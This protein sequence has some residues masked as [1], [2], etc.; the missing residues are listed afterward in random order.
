MYRMIPI[1]PQDR[2]LIGV[3]WDGGV[4]VNR[5]LPFGLRSAPPL[6]TA[7]TDAI[8]WV[9]SRRGHHHWSTTLT[10]L[11]FFLLQ[12]TYHSNGILQWL[13]YTFDN[14]GVPVLRHKIEGPATFITFL[15]IVVDTAKL[16]LHLPAEETTL[17]QHL[18]VFGQN[19]G[20]QITCGLLGSC[21]DHDPTELD[22]PMAPVWHSI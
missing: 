1:H 3:C 9:S 18:Q 8:G 6:F 2:Y 12:S 19:Q 14:L 15:G 7:V 10:S 5:A 17:I 22:I 20:F 13:R 4:F 16:E 21:S 11:F